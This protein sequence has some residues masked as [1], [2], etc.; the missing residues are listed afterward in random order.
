MTGASCAR[1]P[2]I[3]APYPGWMWSERSLGGATMGQL[4][5]SLDSWTW[6][7]ASVVI[8]TMA[9]YLA[10]VGQT[11]AAEYPFFGPAGAPASAF[12]KPDRPVA[13]IIAPL[14]HSEKTRDEAGEP[15]QLVR[16][17][18]IK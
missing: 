17:L 7:G 2:A 18:G 4:A 9:L 1:M 3:C 13:D 8:L 6:R 14:W 11:G 15:A 12:P 5:H 10:S 16:L